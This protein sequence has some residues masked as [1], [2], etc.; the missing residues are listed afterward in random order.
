MFLIHPPGL[1]RADVTPTLLSGYGGAGVNMLPAYAPE[2]V[3]WVEAGG[4]VAVPTL[5]G[6]GEYGQGWHAAGARENKQRA[7]DDLL[8]AADWL[9]GSHYTNADH[10]TV[11]SDAHG[12]LVAAAAVIQRPELFRAAVLTAPIVDMVR[13]PMFPLGA[14]MAPEYGDPRDPAAFRWLLDYSPFHRFAT[15]RGIRRCS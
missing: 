4:L 5:R 9:V 7:I 15:A 13:Y 12:A 8:A 1:G 6:G 3:Q 10:L 14:G 11:S 2:I